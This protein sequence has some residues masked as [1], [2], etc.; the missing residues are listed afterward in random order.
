MKD[1]AP[2][3]SPKAVAI[4]GAS[5]RGHHGKQALDS[6]EAF[7]YPG[8]VYL[9]N[10]A[11]K[12]VWGKPCYPSLAD[13]PTTVDVAILV[14]SRERVLGIVQQCAEVGVR[15][16]IINT[17]GFAE[18]AD[19]VGPQLQREVTKLVQD[20]GILLCGPNC[21][22]VINRHEDV[23][24]YCGPLRAPVMLGGLSFISHSGGNCPSF[25]E[26]AYARNIGMSYVISCG[27]EAALDVCDYLE[28]VLEDPH[29][30][31]VCLFLET[32]RNPRRFLKLAER[33]MAMRKP[34]V[35]VKI[36]KSETARAA[37]LAHTGA[38]VGSDE[39]V[40]ALVD[41]AGIIRSPSLDEAIGHCSLFCLLPQKLWPRGRRLAVFTIGGGLAGLVSDL[42]PE[43]GFELP[44]LPPSITSIL[45][46]EI[47]ETL[48][49][50]NPFDVPGAQLRE[51][52]NIVAT[53]IDACLKSDAYD[54]ALVLKSIPGPASLDYLKTVRGIATKYK[55]PVI[56][57]S[58][59]ESAM[60]DYKR[61]V[62]SDSDVVLVMGPNRTLN[63][64]EAALQ[65]HRSSSGQHDRASKA[66]G[67]KP[68]PA[69]IHT[70]IADQTRAAQAVLDHVTTYQAFE[71]YDLPIVP[72]HV[73]SNEDEALDAAEKLGYPVIAKLLVS[74]QAVHKTE[75][76]GVFTNLRTRE[77]VSQ[78][79]RS[80][81]DV[82]MRRGISKSAS[83]PLLM[84]KA[85]APALEMYL[86]AIVPSGGYPP[87]VV[88]GAGGIYIETLR[89]V[90]RAIAPLD[91]DD[92]MVSLQQ[93]R[94]YPVLRGVR[95]HPGYDIDTFAQCMVRLGD[96]IAAAQD[97]VAEVDLNP[98]LLQPRPAAGGFVVDAVVTLRGYSARP[99][100]SW[101][102]NDPK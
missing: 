85:I 62:M 7:G 42:A 6:L 43:H 57:S 35:C 64:L 40:Q 39:A 54:A 11:R 28:Y 90:I 76:G 86:G 5:E 32:I 41:R 83:I 93:L 23:A 58:P 12:E 8:P 13:T 46:S 97:L 48:H 82:A 10:P 60:E 98:I 20:A 67:V 74:D 14:V 70:C 87:M 88:A 69:E 75:L 9:V 56:A 4:V 24:A 72:Q 50:R 101:S 17:D 51:N 92:A 65:F 27:N 73:V 25:M 91:L 89:D 30:S 47:A 22:G 16:V 80:L 59:V 77:Q 29:T 52:P 53:Y 31:V 81:N 95:G 96:F 15:A 3:L 79:V 63:A 102:L 49:V 44:A 55:K 36:G 68:L 21:L 34:I 37:A 61:A 71:Y 33:A 100:P 45:S 18:S 78:A 94:I 38:L 2:L 19:S 26:L 99:D 1:L 84:Q 66:R